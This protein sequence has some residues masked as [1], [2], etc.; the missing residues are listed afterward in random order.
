[1]GSSLR[2]P[3]F[4][5]ANLSS[6]YYDPALAT[7]LPITESDNHSILKSR[8]QQKP[9]LPNVPANKYLPGR[10]FMDITGK[11]VLVTGGASGL[12]RATVRSFVA[13]ARMPSSLM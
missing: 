2:L 1:M 3:S 11:T 4:N 12:G 6:Q 10:L 7:F 9:G 13:K 5:R 8:L